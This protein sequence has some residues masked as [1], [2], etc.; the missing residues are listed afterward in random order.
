MISRYNLITFV[1]VILKT[2]F[3]NPFNFT[4]FCFL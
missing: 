2:R 1:L 4:K 3:R